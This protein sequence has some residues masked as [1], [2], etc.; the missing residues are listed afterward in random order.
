MKKKML[1]FA[2]S[3]MTI[4]SFLMPH[5]KKL[6]KVFE[7]VI[8]NKSS[9]SNLNY[10]KGIKVYNL[11]VDRK[12]NIFNDIKNLIFLIKFLKKDKF[13]LIFTITPK[14][15][16]LGMFAA[17][18]NNI[19][20]RIHIFTGQV[21]A[22]KNIAYKLFLKFFDKL[23]CNFSTEI[24]CDG[25]NQKKYL[26]QNGFSKSI[27]VIKNG[28]ICG[29]DTKIFKPS[30]LNKK[31][32]KKQFKI[33]EDQIILIYVGR[34]S[35][36]K[37]IHNL[38]NTFKLLKKSDYKVNLFLV[39]K[40]EEFK[41][42]E[43]I[44]EVKDIYHIN[45]TK[46]VHKYYQM[47]DIFITTSYREG[48]GISVAQ[49]MSCKLPIVGTSIYGLKDLLKHKINSLVFEPYNEKTL[50]LNCKKLIKDKKFRNKL[51]K[52]G[53]KLIIKKFRQDVVINQYIEFFRNKLN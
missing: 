14:A 42:K 6:I 50:F 36:D 10:L 24:L 20:H 3:Q 2:T 18:I 32:L 8:I 53:R 52:E 33:S 28:S 11:N 40:I 26:V 19:P 16:L 35:K 31:K 38:I 21:W 37:G 48:F 25:I 29:I 5:I 30:L 51:G 47:A 44:K 39:G 49:A 4:E 23:I 15:G 12:I 43:S 17:Y 45:H 7:I 13:D 9:S 1:I 22:N 27:K 34:L 46:Y 41:L